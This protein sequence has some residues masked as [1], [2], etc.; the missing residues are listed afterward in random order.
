MHT[1]V[2]HERSH[3]GTLSAHRHV[4]LY[5]Q[6]LCGILALDLLLLTESK[7]KTLVRHPFLPSLLARS[8]A[9]IRVSILPSLLLTVCNRDT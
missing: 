3:L 9:K 5:L 4:T 6:T 8:T 2:K 7:P 1:L